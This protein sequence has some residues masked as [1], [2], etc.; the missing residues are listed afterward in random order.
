MEEFRSIAHMVIHVLAPGA[1]AGSV[2]RKRWKWA[3]G[4]MLATMVVDLDHLLAE[5]IYDPNR[6]GI[7]FH[8]LHSY[9]AIVGY[10]LL[11]WVPGARIVAA[12]LL[13]HM[14]ADGL[15]CVWQHYAAASA[16]RAG[17]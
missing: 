3:W 4:L 6:C 15:D 13:V 9:P 14:G 2:F 5:P 1:V 16:A 10:A 11:L 12:G 7:G 17:G 8:P